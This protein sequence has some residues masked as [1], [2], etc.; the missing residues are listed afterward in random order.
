MISKSGSMD[1]LIGFKLLNNSPQREMRDGGGYGRQGQCYE[2]MYDVEHMQSEMLALDAIIF[3]CTLMGCRRTETIQIDNQFMTKLM[4]G[5]TV[6]GTTFVDRYVK[7]GMLAQVE[8]LLKGLLDR[9]IALSN[10]L[11]VGYTKHNQVHEALVPS[12]RCKMRAF[13]QTLSP[14]YAS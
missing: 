6:F 7:C 1:L 4:E 14:S 13:P 9:N 3:I 8:N 12:S 5:D 11:I 2:V 10:V